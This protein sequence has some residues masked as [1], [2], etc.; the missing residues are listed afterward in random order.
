M[1]ADQPL[2]EHLEG[3]WSNKCNWK[4]GNISKWG[5][6]WNV[7]ISFLCQSISFTENWTQNFKL[8]VKTP[9]IHIS[10]GILFG[11]VAKNHGTGQSE[12]TEPYKKYFHMWRSAGGEMTP[13]AGILCD[14]NVT[15]RNS[16]ITLIRL[17][18]KKFYLWLWPKHL[19]AKTLLISLHD[20]QQTETLPLD[21]IR[22]HLKWIEDHRDFRGD[23]SPEKLILIKS[24][25]LFLLGRSS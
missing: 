23:L 20:F 6:V 10:T 14:I 5:L 25:W 3:L 4:W 24:H 8:L 11:L 16:E 1:A 2:C 22:K 9:Q 13:D 19:T 12:P 7:A 18:I 21:A 15:I 17:L